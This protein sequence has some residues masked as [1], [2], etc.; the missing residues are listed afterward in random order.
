MFYEVLG[1]SKRRCYVVMFGNAT[2]SPTCC[3]A[4]ESESL[5]DVATITKV[6]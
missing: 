4:L 2:L 6:E 3:R 1:C 5:W